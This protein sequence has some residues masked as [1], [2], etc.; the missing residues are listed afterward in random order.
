MSAFSDLI[1]NALLPTIEAVGESKIVD[2]LQKLHDSEP[3]KYKLVMEAGFAFITPLEKYTAGTTTKI[4]DGFVA[5]IKE[6]IVLSA[7]NNG[8]QL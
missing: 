5:A 1:V 2:V 4:D 3:D 7:A 6:A 8:L